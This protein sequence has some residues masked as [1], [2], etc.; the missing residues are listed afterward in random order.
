MRRKPP[1]DKRHETSTVM[2]ERGSNC[3]LQYR[4]H[5]TKQKKT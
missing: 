2:L 4:G 1:S 5:N 3:Q